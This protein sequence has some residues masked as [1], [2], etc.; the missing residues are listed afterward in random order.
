VIWK[1]VVLP[2]LET[3]KS[4]LVAPLLEVE[5]TAKITLL[6]D[7]EAACTESVAKGDEVPNPRFPVVE[8][9]RK[10]PTPAFPNRTVDD[11]FK[12]PRSESVVPVALVL[13]PKL[14]VG[15]KG[16]AKVW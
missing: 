4:V 1:S 16:K 3:L 8:S 2:V 12:P 9:K 14:F 10:P 6:S 11:A 13:T 7:V 5:A 15:V